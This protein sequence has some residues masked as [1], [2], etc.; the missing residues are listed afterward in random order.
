MWAV[1]V[2]LYGAFDSFRFVA[3]GIM[4]GSFGSIPPVW[5]YAVFDASMGIPMASGSVLGGLLY[6]QGYALPFYTVIAISVVMLLALALAGRA[7]RSPSSR[8]SHSEPTTAA[9]DSA[10]VQAG[11]D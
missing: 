1:A 7:R 4:S 9:A 11:I 8:A 6:R 10:P 5:G 3:A 2:F